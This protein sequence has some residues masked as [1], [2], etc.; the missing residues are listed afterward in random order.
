MPKIRLKIDG[1][2]LEVDEGKTVLEA[3]RA[4]GIY[5][6]TLCSHPE[7]P[8]LK[9]LEPAALVY[10]GTEKVQG[11]TPP[12]PGSEAAEGCR[13]CIVEVEGQE[14]F[15]TSCN[16]P[17]AESMVVVTDSPRLKAKRQD[18]LMPY[19]VDHPHAC[20]TCAQH[21]GCVR[22]P[23]SSNV[24][25]PERCCPRLGRCEFEKV[26]T[27][28][29]VKPETTKYRPQGLPVLDQEPLFKRD[30]NLCIGCARCVR[31]CKDLRGVGALGFVYRG[32]KRLVG[33]S[34]PAPKESDC[35]FCG[36][37]V[38][39]CPTGALV[40][41]DPKASQEKERA[42][43]LVP[44]RSTCPA[45]VDIPRYIRCISEGRVDEAFAVVRE[46][47]PVFSRSLSLVCL[48]PCEKA[49]RRGEVNEPVAICDLK[50]FAAEKGAASHRMAKASSGKRVAVVGG[51]PAGLTA[52]YYLAL[53]GHTVTV[54]ESEPKLGG[55]TRI[56]IPRYRLPVHVLDEDIKDLVGL[57]LDIRTGTS[58]GKDI[59]FKDL[60]DGGYDAIFLAIGAQLSRRIRIEG[61]DHPRVLWGLDFLR[62]VNKG[63]RVDLR[64][65]RVVV[66][67]GGNVA[68]D[69]ALTAR[70]LGTASLELA[71]LESRDIMPASEWEVKEA[72]EEGINLNCSWGPKRVI[73]ENGALK[74]IEFKRCTRVFDETGRFNPAYDEAATTTLPCDIIIVAIG[75]ASDLGL[76]GEPSPIAFERGIVKTDPDTLQTSNPRVFAGGDLVK[77]PGSIV[78]AVAAGRKA[79]SNIDKLLG[80]PGIVDEA[81]VDVKAPAPY[82]GKVEGFAKLHRAIPGNLDAQDPGRK[83]GFA[84]VYS[85]LDKEAAIAEANRCLR[86]DLRLLILAVPWPPERVL[87]FA[88]EAIAKVPDVEGVYRLFDGERKVLKIA[89]VPNLRESLEKD[90]KT[91]TKAKFFDIEEEKM[92]SKRESELLQQYIQV[93]GKMPEGAGGGDDIEDL[94]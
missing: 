28:I 51:G 83:D 23:C 18:L 92:Y 24:P 89:G 33:L 62:A 87:V 16:T 82:L 1:T 52:A 64:G 3:A 48:R 69:V 72:C 37:C 36:A 40:D 81:T 12:V 43:V 63:E 60:L 25:V 88:A 31:A 50:R 68:I 5:I 70:R 59:P 35:R 93:H 27:Y 47:L 10:R 26:V 7:L 49:C 85:C 61:I 65:K 53:S 19:L 77:M 11:D 66:I 42:A 91:A 58:V 76:L 54:F 34:G 9:G 17:A 14:A 55:M 6:P 20:L 75:Q 30:F 86:C 22:E 41:K 13:L 73:V 46:R 84:E 15:I 67:G 39:V 8:P 44:C 74:G 32:G 45:G 80:G 4:G 94:F 29:G 90:L 2:D 57:G 56:G 71:C 38:E 21:E 78:D 79:A